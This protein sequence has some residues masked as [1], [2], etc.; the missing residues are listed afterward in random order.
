MLNHFDP[1]LVVVNFAG[2]RLLMLAEGQH[3]TAERDE[4]AYAK[5]VGTGGDVIRS[6]NN[7]R[8]G[9]VKLSIMASSPSNDF[10]S[11]MARADELGGA[12]G[13][14]LDIA[15]LNGTTVVTAPQAWVKKI[16]G[17]VV[18]KDAADM[19]REWEFDCAEL[20]IFIGG[21]VA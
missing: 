4:D 8:S 17:L 16:P 20:D 21:F 19:T 12:G 9:S 13:G 11:A 7:N 3:I 2:Q 15:D 6:R 1:K 14:G 18:A 5:T 10:L